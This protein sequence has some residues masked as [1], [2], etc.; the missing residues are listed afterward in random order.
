M[1]RP[2]DGP[3]RGRAVASDPGG[4]ERPVGA[5]AGDVPQVAVAH[6]P[7]GA[8]EATVV[9]AGDDPVADP[10]DGPV[11]GGDAMARDEA[12]GG[13]VVV[14]AGVQGADGAGVGG[15]EDG[16]A[17]VFGVG[18][19]G[20]VGLF[21]HGHPGA[22][23]DAVVVLV[24]VEHPEVTVAQAAGGGGLPGAGEPPQGRQHGGPAAFGQQVERPAGVDG[25]QL[26]VVADGEHLGAGDHAQL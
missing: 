26:G 25:G 9:G 15:D 21:E 12:G 5:D 17:S 24:D 6:V 7:A 3:G 19:P 20:G 2:G 14:G 13:A 1:P 11:G 16:W 10:D 4:G 23:A 18:L 22:A 8:P